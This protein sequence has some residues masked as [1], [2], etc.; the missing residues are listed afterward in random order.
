M[1]SFLGLYFFSVMGTNVFPKEPVPPVIKMV[2][3]FNMSYLIIAHNSLS[4]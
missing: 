3:F 4:I 2:L 1:M